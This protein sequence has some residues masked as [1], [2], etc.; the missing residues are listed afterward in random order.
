MPIVLGASQEDYAAAAPPGSYIHVDDFN[1]PQELALY[2]D[3]L[4]KDDTLYNQYFAWKSQ[5][6]MIDEKYWCMICM[7]LHLQE[8]DGYRHWYPNYHRFWNLCTVNSGYF[9][10]V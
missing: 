1:N 9:K 5:Y 8:E 4:D 10:K 3:R 7:L 2:L 6:S